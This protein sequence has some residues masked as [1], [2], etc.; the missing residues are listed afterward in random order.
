MNY[1]SKRALFAYFQGILE[2]AAE[3]FHEK[4]DVKLKPLDAETARAEIH[5]KG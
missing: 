5:F 2:G 3:F 1:H 4:V